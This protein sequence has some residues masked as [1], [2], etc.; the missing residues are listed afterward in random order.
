MEVYWTL[1]IFSLK[2]VQSFRYIHKKSWKLQK[3]I[4]QKTE[5]HKMNHSSIFYDILL[6]KSLQ[7]AANETPPTPSNFLRLQIHPSERKEEVLKGARTDGAVSGDR[8]G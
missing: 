1:Y 8:G 6:L 3:Q 2:L 5:F 7:S 4:I